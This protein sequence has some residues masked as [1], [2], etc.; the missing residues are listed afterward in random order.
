LK[1]QTVVYLTFNKVLFG[2]IRIFITACTKYIP[3]HAFF[4]LN[5]SLFMVHCLNDSL[6][7]T[8]SYQIF[9]LIFLFAV[10][11]Y[12]MLYSTHPFLCNGCNILNIQ[13]VLCMS[14]LCN[15]LQNFF[16]FIAWARISAALHDKVVSSFIT[17][18]REMRWFHFLILKLEEL[19]SSKT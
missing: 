4:Q 11:V 19:N 8:F 7:S 5:T 6:L 15:I 12:A 9:L 13:Y 17:M 10:Y 16:L 14:S 2:E 1:L 18:L 3:N